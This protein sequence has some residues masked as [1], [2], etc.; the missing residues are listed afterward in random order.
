MM[1]SSVSQASTH[2]TLAPKDGA[3]VQGDVRLESPVMAPN[4]LSPRTVLVHCTITRS[5]N[6]APVQGNVWLAMQSMLRTPVLCVKPLNDPIELIFLKTLEMPARDASG[7]GWH[8]VCKTRVGCTNEFKPELIRLYPLT[9]QSSDQ[10]LDDVVAVIRAFRAHALA[11][12]AAKEAGHT[13][14]TTKS[15]FQHLCASP[16]HMSRDELPEYFTQ[17]IVQPS[18][19]E[20]CSLLSVCPQAAEEHAE[21]CNSENDTAEDPYAVDGVVSRLSFRDW[22]KLESAWYRLESAWYRWL[23]LYR[24]SWQRRFSSNAHEDTSDSDCDSPRSSVQDFRSTQDLR[25]LDHAWFRW[26]QFVEHRRCYSSSCSS[27]SDDSFTEGMYDDVLEFGCYSLRIPT[28]D[29][30]LP[31]HIRSSWRFDCTISFDESD[32][33]G[34]WEL[35]SLTALDCAGEL[36]MIRYAISM[37]TMAFEE[38]AATAISWEHEMSLSGRLE[39]ARFASQM[40]SLKHHWENGRG[41]LRRQHITRKK[42]G[43]FSTKRG[44]RQHKHDLRRARVNRQR[45]MTDDPRPAQ[46][47]P[48]FRS[49][50]SFAPP[51][52]PIIP[53][54][55]TKDVF[56]F[57]ATAQSTPSSIAFAP[58][59]SSA[60]LSPSLSSLTSSSSE[61]SSSS[62]SGLLKMR[63]MARRPKKRRDCAL[64]RSAN[65]SVDPRSYGIV[66]CDRPKVTT[67]SDRSKLRRARCKLDCPVPCLGLLQPDTLLCPMDDSSVEDSEQASVAS[68]VPLLVT[69]AFKAG[70]AK[71]GTGL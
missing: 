32:L 58:A 2:C 23:N 1:Q 10:Q 4:V 17:G 53:L 24:D 30:L 7:C 16:D 62:L 15:D 11:T 60:T 21:N 8:L 44:R 12:A 9:P 18:I 64:H 69:R 51:T 22:R 34:A 14:P 70:A 28:Q 57:G 33:D 45:G 68:T 36:E 61:L 63:S 56:I 55:T 42:S 13:V 41:R 48:Q 71:E 27:C 43:N 59:S 38:D 67:Q 3:P 54:A 52:A 50:F 26:L 46:P 49:A 19:L 65:L 66:A 39:R 37:S 31:H 40:A 29:C 35:P 6:G 20:V 25:V 47:E 5:E